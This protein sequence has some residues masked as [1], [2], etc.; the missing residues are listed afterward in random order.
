MLA[1][2]GWCEADG[3]YCYWVRLQGLYVER[4]ADFLGRGDYLPLIALEPGELF[5]LL[6]GFEAS[7]QIREGKEKAL[8][9]HWYYVPTQL[10]EDG[11]MTLNVMLLDRD[12]DTDDDLVLPMRRHILRLDRDFPRSDRVSVEIPEM[13]VLDDRSSDSNQMRFRV[14]LRRKPGPCRKDTPQGASADTAY[15]RE[16]RLH[17][18]RSRVFHYLDNPVIAGREALLF[19]E[20]TTSSIE[21][22]YQIAQRNLHELVTLGMEIDRLEGTRGFEDLQYEFAQL[23][24]RLKKK[25]LPIKV[26]A[27]KG[28]SEQEVAYAPA[29]ASDPRWTVLIQGAVVEPMPRRWLLSPDDR[30]TREGHGQSPAPM[31]ESLQ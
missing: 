8:D 7:M 19:V 16:N 14:E 23:I 26:P 28:K 9:G 3:G 10:I 22:A 6:P 21:A 15:R 31:H 12:E 24:E 20:N 18:L 25:R 11:A 13:Y 2:S 27:Q 4:S 1:V 30:A 17:H 5:S 29:L